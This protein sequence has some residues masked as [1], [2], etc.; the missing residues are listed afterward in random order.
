[1]ILNLLDADNE[2]SEHGLLAISK[3]VSSSGIDGA[4]IVK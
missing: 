1:V 3:L 2:I 4:L